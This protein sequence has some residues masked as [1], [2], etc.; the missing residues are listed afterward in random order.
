[1]GAVEIAGTGAP[2]PAS[3]RGR[4]RSMFGKLT[5]VYKEF[6]A[7]G[8]SLYLVDRL[9]R[10][11]SDRT[12]LIVYDLMVQPLDA[13]SP[14][15]ARPLK[16][17]S[18]RQITAG[19]PELRAVPVP[20]AVTES[21]FAQG[22]TCLGIFKGEALAGYIW[23]ASG[24]YDEDEVRCRYVLGRPDEAVFDFDLYIFPQHRLGF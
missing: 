1:M 19:D 24:A 22:A 18:R 7:V 20:A 5:G 6:G 17:F 21:R 14:K 15:L 23:F 3:G 16:G 8:G 2:R 9:L 4:E 10:A 11:F 13:P 12:R